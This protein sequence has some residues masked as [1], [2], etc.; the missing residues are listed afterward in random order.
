[1]AFARR[2]LCLEDLQVILLLEKIVKSNVMRFL[3]R[4]KASPRLQVPDKGL[5]V[6]IP[7]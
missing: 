3:H 1:M 7:A 2:K 6:K 5:T 4:K